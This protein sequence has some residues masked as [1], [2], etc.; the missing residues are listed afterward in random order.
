MGALR[1]GNRKIHHSIDHI[2]LCFQDIAI[3]FIPELGG[4]FLL[5]D[6]ALKSFC[7]IIQSCASSQNQL[8]RTVAVFLDRTATI[9][10]FFVFHC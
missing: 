3:P 10:G 4:Q 8:P 1:R 5:T 9:Y 2:L 6:D 7:S